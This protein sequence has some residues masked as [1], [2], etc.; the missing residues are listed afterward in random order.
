MKNYDLRK[1]MQHKMSKPDEKQ[2]LIVSQNIYARI[3]SN[4]SF[5]LNVRKVN[6]VLRKKKCCE[7]MVIKVNSTGKI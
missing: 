2:T 4:N 1:K 5:S 7:Q 3:H 6:P